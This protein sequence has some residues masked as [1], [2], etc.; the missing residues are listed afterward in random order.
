MVDN[1]EIIK[2][3]NNSYLIFE[4]NMFNYD[5]LSELIKISTMTITC[6]LNKQF[7]LKNDIFENIIFS[8]DNLNCVKFYGDIKINN[9]LFTN[10]DLKELK[11]TFLEDENILFFDNCILI[12]KESKYDFKNCKNKK[13]IDVLKKIKHK[14]NSNKFFNQMTIIID[15]HTNPNRK[16]S[17]IIKKAQNKKI[18]VK[19]FNNASWF[20]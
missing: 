6:K 8:Y 13:F 12:K 7:K 16:N 17:Y 18:N 4:K 9:L 20:S 2:I 14:N 11:N 1:N 10:D 5:H 19:I 15:I 3:N